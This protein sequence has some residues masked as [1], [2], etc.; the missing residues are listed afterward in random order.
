MGPRSRRGKVS[1]RARR[2]SRGRLSFPSPTAR[3]AGLGGGSGDWSLQAMHARYILSFL[4]YSPATRHR[5][6]SE[7]DISRSADSAASCPSS[8]TVQEGRTRCGR[9]AGLPGQGED[10][11]L[12][13]PA[14]TPPRAAHCRPGHPTPTRPGKA[15]PLRPLVLPGPGP[16]PLHAAQDRAAHDCST[17]KILAQILLKLGR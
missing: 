14:P 2:G 13:T 6:C 10:A 5:L 8:R 3:V 15:L 9:C 1:G 17:L 16:R 4:C 11:A 7:S 12:T